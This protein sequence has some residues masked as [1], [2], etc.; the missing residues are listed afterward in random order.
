MLE[1]LNFLKWRYWLAGSLIAVVGL[2]FLFFSSSPVALFVTVGIIIAL[3][4]LAVGALVIVQKKR[5]LIFALKLSFAVIFFA[6][7]IVTS[8]LNKASIGVLVS[9]ICLLLI[10]DGAFK[11]QTSIKSKKYSIEGWWIIM[12]I[13][14]SV[15]LSAF[16][17]VRIFPKSYSGTAIWL[18]ITLIADASAN[19]L[20]SFWS[21]KCKTAERAEIYYEVYQDN[22]D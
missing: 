15:I 7:G 2:C 5:D 18:G 11:L 9:V 10:V 8:I 13:S 4:G 17:L 19:V 6:G 16:L 12:I 21:A 3:L 22:P 20:S 1:K 14:V